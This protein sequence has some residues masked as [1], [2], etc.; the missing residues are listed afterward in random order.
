MFL[1]LQY[2]FYPNPATN[3]LTITLQGDNKKNEV[4]IMDITGK[5]FYSTTENETQELKINT[6]DFAEGVYLVQVK[7][8]DFMATKKLV[9]KK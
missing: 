7:S 1:L 4:T 8:E 9:V 3:Y 6:K 2:L 5:I